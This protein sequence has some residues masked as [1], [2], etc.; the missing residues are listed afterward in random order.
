MVCIRLSFE[1]LSVNGAIVG[2]LV[3]VLEMDVLCTWFNSRLPGNGK[4]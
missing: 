2:E 1:K 3:F 4:Q